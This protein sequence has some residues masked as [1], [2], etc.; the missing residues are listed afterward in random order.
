MRTYTPIKVVIKVL[1]NIVVHHLLVL[2]L[3]L[4]LSLELVLGLARVMVRINEGYG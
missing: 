3:G 1:P 4:V 2:G